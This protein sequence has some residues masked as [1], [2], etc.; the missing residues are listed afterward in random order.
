MTDVSNIVTRLDTDKVL[1]QSVYAASNGAF[2]IP[3]ASR[4]DLYTRLSSESNPV[5]DVYPMMLPD[6]HTDGRDSIVYTLEDME[7]FEIDGYPVSQT[8]TY[9]LRCRS[10][11]AESLDTLIDHVITSLRASSFAVEPVGVA[12]GYEDDQQMFFADFMIE[13]TYVL[14]SDGNPTTTLPV[15]ILYPLGRQAEPAEYDNLVKQRV[16]DQ[17]G[18]ILVTQSGNIPALMDEVRASLLGYAQAS[19]YFDMEYVSGQNLGGIS[20]LELW[21]EIYTDAQTITEA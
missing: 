10:K 3:V 15:A 1:L 17:Y 7:P 4:E 9:K 11:R 6:G 16:E 5:V 8:D 13:Y 2:G 12:D 19:T 20:D 21:R 14:G 18:I